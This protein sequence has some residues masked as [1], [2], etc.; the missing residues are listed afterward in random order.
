MV[1][2]LLRK[3]AKISFP[4]FRKQPPAM[5]IVTP[6]GHGGSCADLVVGVKRDADDK[7]LGTV[8]VGGGKVLGSL[9][10]SID[11]GELVLQD[12]EEDCL[13]VGVI[14]V[15]QG[16]RVLHAAEDWWGGEHANLLDD[17]SVGLQPKLEMYSAVGIAAA[18]LFG[19]RPVIDHTST[20]QATL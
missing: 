20:C 15:V 9:A 5:F 19:F 6:E 18:I 10:G 3:E 14:K 1:I 11:G 8:D 17:G 2:I 4:Y 7:A 12:V 16:V 13:E